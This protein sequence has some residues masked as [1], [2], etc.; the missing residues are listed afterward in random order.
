MLSSSEIGP[1]DLIFATY[2]PWGAHY[3]STEAHFG[4]RPLFPR[5]GVVFDARG[6]F[7]TDFGPFWPKNSPCAPKRARSVANMRSVGPIS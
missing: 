6:P 4:F 1:T 3:K 7:L 2:L 5:F